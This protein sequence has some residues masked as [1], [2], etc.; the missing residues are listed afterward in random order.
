MKGD[1]KRRYCGQCRLH[2]HNLSAMK[3]K[4]RNE[5][6]TA[7]GGKLCIAYELRPD[8]AMVTPPRWSWLARTFQ[9]FRWVAATVAASFIPALFSSCTNRR[10]LGETPASRDSVTLSS[11]GKDRGGMTKGKP[12]MM[13]GTPL[14][15]TLPAPGPDSGA[16]GPPA[17]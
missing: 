7:T 13:L 3:E 10:I 11:A 5:L 12:A 2:V 6:L 8:G 1:S 9:P 16:K 17:N 14:A 15:P 4:E